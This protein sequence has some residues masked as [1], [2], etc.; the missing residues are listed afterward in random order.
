[1]LIISKVLALLGERK[2]GKTKASDTRTI[3][4]ETSQE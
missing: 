3:E 4:E 2:E 1:M